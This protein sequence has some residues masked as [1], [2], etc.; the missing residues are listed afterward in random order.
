MSFFLSL[1]VHRH[2]LQARPLTGSFLLPR[3]EELK[4][5]SISLSGNFHPQQLS[6]GIS[7]SSIGKSNFAISRVPWSRVCFSR[8]SETRC[9]SM[10]TFYFSIGV[11]PIGISALVMSKTTRFT[12]P[13]SPIH[14]T[15]M[16]S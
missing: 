12:S 10:L 8:F 15:P 14:E 1:V 5:S 4:G 6:H 16:R 11:P 2:S 9:M 3:P 7:L 13:R